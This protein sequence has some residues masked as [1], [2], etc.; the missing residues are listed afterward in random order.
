MFTS[1]YQLQ[2][3]VHVQTWSC[4]LNN[5]SRQLHTLILCNQK[6]ID[7]VETVTF[8]KEPKQEK[9]NTELT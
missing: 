5:M 4:A 7:R 2:L 3:N 9:V 6:V 1:M 8:T